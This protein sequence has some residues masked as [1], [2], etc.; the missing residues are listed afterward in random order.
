MSNN[1]TPLIKPNEILK[2][3]EIEFL[4]KKDDK[5][6]SLLIL[7]AWFV[8]LL[9]V[10]IYSLFPN[11]VTFFLAVILI[12]GRQLGLAILMHEGAHGLIN[13]KIKTNDFI[14]Q[15]FCA[16][17]VWLDTYGYRHYHL[18]HHRHTQKENDPDLS[19]SKPFPISKM[20][21]LRKVLRDLSGISGL[22]QKYELIF[23]T[24]LNKEVV[25]SDGKIISGFKSTNTLIGIIFS[26]LFIFLIMWFLGEWWYFF[27]FWLLPLITF[28]QLF[29][30]I[31][32][33][34]EHAGVKPDCDDF[35]NART[36]YANLF[37]RAFVAP[38]YVNYHLEHHL[39]MFIPCYKLKRAHQMMLNNGHHDKMEIKSGYISLLKS[40]L[41]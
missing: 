28:F 8:I 1:F 11:I 27:V 40:V 33:I 41:V 17:P 5:T 3:D 34:A 20:S 29:L 16:F 6:G 13:N 36:T 38:Y 35:D 2:E 37:E 15:W 10:L 12:G 4:K 31:R 24:L 32:N 22:K 21:F 7:H 30:R 25:K 26:N 14:S 9:C 23:K 19:L 39:L 18:S